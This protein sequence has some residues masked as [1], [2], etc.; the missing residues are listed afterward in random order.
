MRPRLWPTD[1]AS[2]GMP[3]AAVDACAPSCVLHRTG[4]DR[5]RPRGEI[6]CR[7][8]RPS[9]LSRS[10][11]KAPGWLPQHQQSRSGW[12]GSIHAARCAALPLP[13]DWPPVRDRDS[14]MFNGRSAAHWHTSSHSSG[15][16]RPRSLS[17]NMHG[18]ARVALKRSPRQ[19]AYVASTSDFHDAAA[20]LISVSVANRYRHWP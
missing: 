7:R 5:P 16:Q 4:F 13:H 8:P 3:G 1:G 12:S 11:A 18:A 19:S 20:F 14:L 10:G 6:V 17:F 9:A 15:C 2:A